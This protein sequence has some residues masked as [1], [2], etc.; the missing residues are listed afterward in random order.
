[1]TISADT[2]NRAIVKSFE[3]MIMSH[4]RLDGVLGEVLHLLRWGPRDLSMILVAGPTGAGKTTVLD[5]IEKQLLK[6]ACEEMRQDP[7]YFPFLRVNA[8][9]P[10]SGDFRFRDYFSRIL[11]KAHE[12]CIG[13]KIS[14]RPLHTIEI[15]GVRLRGPLST[16]NLRIAVEHCL[17]YRRVPVILVDDAEHMAKVVDSRRLRDYM[18]VLKSLTKETG[19]RWVLTGTYEE[20][21]LVDLSGQNV[22]LSA[23][24]HFS[25][26]KTNSKADRTAFAETLRAMLKRLPAGSWDEQLFVNY[27]M[28]LFE[29]SVGCVGLLKGWLTLA[30]GSAME[31]GVPLSLEHCRKWERSLSQ[32]TKLAEEISYGEAEMAKRQKLRASPEEGSEEDDHL[33]ATLHAEPSDSSRSSTMD[34]GQKNPSAAQADNR[35]RRKRGRVGTRKPIRDPVGMPGDAHGSVSPTT[36]RDGVAS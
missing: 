27:W 29:R 21:P 10:D 2:D 7:G 32:L 1:M 15:P 19:V 3:R 33:N 36:A 20:L 4:P 18:D 35:K 8:V 13:D 25:R 23:D 11:M 16:D 30:L 34:H 17:R 24:I 22:R 12:P 28:Y 14:R 5:L 31:K 26:Y 9:P 6:D